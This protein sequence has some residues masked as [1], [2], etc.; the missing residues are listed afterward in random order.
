MITKLKGSAARQV[1]GYVESWL[2]YRRRLLRV[3]G[4]QAAI[5]DESGLV[6]QIADGNAD[7]EAGTAMTPGHLFRIASHSKTF[8]ATVI[9][10]LI[11]EGVL[12]ADDPAARHLPWLAAGPLDTITVRELLSHSSGLIRDG[13]MADW[14]QLGRPFPDHDQLEA[15]A[16]DEALLIE[17]SSRFKYS[18]IGFSLLG[19]VIAA[20]TGTSY[21]SQVRARVIDRLSLSDTDPELNTDRLADYAVGYSALGY[22]EHR[23]P[24]DHVDTRAMSAATGFSSTASDVCRY[25]AAHFEGDDRLLS[26]HSKRVM[27][28]PSWPIP[29]GDKHYGL[30]FE[31]SE[32]AGVGLIGHGGG[33]PGHS[34]RTLIDPAGSVAVSVLTNAIDGPAASWA[35]GVIKIIAAAGEEPGEG[36][37]CGLTEDATSRF[38]GRYASLWGVLDLVR[39]GDR[40]MLISPGAD[41]PTEGPTVLV[42]DGE[43]RLS[44]V[45]AG[46]NGGYG[47]QLA[48]SFATDGSVR[49]ISGPSGI[50]QLPI[51][52]V[53]EFVTGHDRVG[54]GDFPSAG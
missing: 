14:W 54:L 38:C 20:A 4:V 42:P 22:A 26:D 43:D 1:A 32:V 51:D 8:T 25:A 53:S 18:N 12:R 52:R 40:L 19:E 15:L 2:A 9:M 30:G 35:D 5:V 11:E 6:R 47:E 39:L 3:P 28:H 50:T 37:A 7:V 45:R 23:V 34:T 48:F 21:N 49:S 36:E 24:I 41:D 13:R 17:S 29:G 16:G 44:V 10:Q 33:Y 46:G 31:T 27:R